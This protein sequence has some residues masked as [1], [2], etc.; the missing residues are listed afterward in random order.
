MLIGPEHK[1]ALRSCHGEATCEHT[2][3]IY[4][5]LKIIIKQHPNT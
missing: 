2:S 4:K 5:H 1:S 3:V